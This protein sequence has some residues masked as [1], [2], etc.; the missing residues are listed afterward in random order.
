[1]LLETVIT[2][3][4]VVFEII[5]GVSLLIRPKWLRN[6]PKIRYIFEKYGE[7]KASIY[8]FSL[9]ILVI[10]AGIVQFLSVY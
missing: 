10:F 2:L 8:Y 5:F 4:L 9:G 1:M 3:I 7:K 6:L